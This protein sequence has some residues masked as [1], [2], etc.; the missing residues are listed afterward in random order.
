MHTKTSILGVEVDLVSQSQLYDITKEY[1]SNDKL[2]IYFLLTS[3]LIKAAE[4]NEEYRKCLE[5]ADLMLPGEQHMTTIGEELSLL[6]DV[7]LNYDALLTMAKELT[8]KKMVFLLCENNKEKEHLKEYMKEH[9]PKFT[10]VG[11]YCY[12]ENLGDD[13]IINMINT[14]APDIIISTLPTPLQEEWIVTYCSKVNAKLYIGMGGVIDAMIF[15]NKQPP[16][17]IK[18]LHLEGLYHKIKGSNNSLRSRIFKRKLAHYNSK[19]G[20]EDNG[21]VL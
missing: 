20:E 13:Q 4:E 19:K 8:E 16:S 9:L 21:T 17:F 2:N 10:V 11:E 1:L 15:E 5:Q 14:F 3:E 7:A 18:N 6:P 12:E